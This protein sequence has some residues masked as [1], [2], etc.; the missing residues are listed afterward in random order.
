MSR[1]TYIACV[2]SYMNTLAGNHSKFLRT[3]IKRMGL[4]LRRS[5]ATTMSVLMVKLLCRH[6][7]EWSHTSTRS[8]LLY[9]DKWSGSHPGFYPRVPT[10]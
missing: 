3:G 8:E 10:V 1:Y 6:M 4:A 2:V 5:V 7:G 9:Q